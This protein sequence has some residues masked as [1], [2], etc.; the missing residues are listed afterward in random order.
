MRRPFG[1]SSDLKREPEND[2]SES[3][4]FFFPL[5]TYIQHSTREHQMAKTAT[6][7]SPK[8]KEAKLSRT[9]SKNNAKSE[10]KSSNGNIESFRHA[11]SFPK[12]KESMKILDTNPKFRADN[13]GGGQVEL[14]NTLWFRS[15]VGLVALQGVPG[16]KAT[17]CGMLWAM[18]KSISRIE[19]E[20]TAII[21]ARGGTEAYKIATV[22]TLVLGIPM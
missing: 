22:T 13:V 6:K 14:N 4:G 10:V 11:S 21:P 3:R 1:L 5:R 17:A 16:D 8:T 2:P 19:G 18:G 15:N 12:S 7:Q 9:T 20:I